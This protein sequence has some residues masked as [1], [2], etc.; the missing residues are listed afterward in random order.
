MKGYFT[1]GT[2]GVCVVAA[3]FYLTLNQTA[4]RA[5]SAQ[6]PKAGS[7]VPRFEVDP[8]WPKPLPHE[9]TLGPVSGIAADSR[10]H[11]WIIH[12]VKQAPGTPAPDVIEFDQQGNIV[13]TWTPGTG[14]GYEWMDQVHGITVDTNDHVWISGNG[15]TDAHILEFD[16]SGRVLKQIGHAGKN[17]GSNDTQNLGRSTQVRLDSQANEIYVSD[18]E[19]NQ[20]HRVVV[21]DA[22]SGAYKRHWGAYGERPDDSAVTTVFD[23]NAAPPKQFSGAVHCVRLTRDGLVYVCDRG[24]DRFQIFRRDGTFLKEFF[25][26]KETKGQ[27]SVWDIEYSPD[28]KFMY[29]ADGTNQHVWILLRD[30]LQVLGSFGERGSKP[31]QFA[32]GVHDLAVDSKGNIFT[33][34]A[35][36][37]GRVQRFLYKGLSG[38]E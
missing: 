25:L 35:E 9:W 17:G 1:Q 33:G 16:R 21:F 26:A 4:A 11:I 34:E 19:R 15:T 7:G 30:Q 20:N 13:Q 23:P 8:S 14:T 10:D 18:G 36:T 12:R 24:N 6:I 22:T 2:L 27:G 28:Q 32:T 38:G 37:G 5:V 29:V 31:G 3:G